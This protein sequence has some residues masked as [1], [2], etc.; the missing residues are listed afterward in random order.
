LLLAVNKNLP[1]IPSVGGLLRPK[2]SEP[3]PVLGTANWA[4]LH[5]VGEVGFSGCGLQGWGMDDQAKSRSS[6]LAGRKPSVKSQ[7][8]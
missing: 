4:I 2:T 1:L 6:P 3:A 8:S 7:K 5:Q